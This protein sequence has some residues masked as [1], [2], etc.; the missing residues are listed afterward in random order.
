MIKQVFPLLSLDKYGTASSEPVPA[1]PQ[2]KR[3]TVSRMLFQASMSDYAS[4][5]LQS[6]QSFKSDGSAM[7][8]YRV[9]DQ[10]REL[11]AKHKA[12][13]DYKF[14]VYRPNIK[15]LRSMGMGKKG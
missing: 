3:L 5:K 11:D 10:A 2:T 15:L 14:D 4:A 8:Q 1:K 12:R 9:T 6:A 7:R 13:E